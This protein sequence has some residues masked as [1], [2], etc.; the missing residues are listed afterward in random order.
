M[1]SQLN[2][3]Y[4][5]GGAAVDKSWGALADFFPFFLRN[6]RKWV[7]CN[8]HIDSL[9]TENRL[10]GFLIMV[11]P[12]VPGASSR[13]LK[14]SSEPVS[15]LRPAPSNQHKGK[16]SYIRQQVARKCGK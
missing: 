10:C 2:L 7:G 8:L 4:V 3:I 5:G 1:L 9:W 15:C 16:Q 11:W 14:T 12:I 13:P 6:G